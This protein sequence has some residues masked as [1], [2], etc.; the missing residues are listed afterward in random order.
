MNPEVYQII[1][2][3]L[4][5]ALFALGGTEIS[6]TIKGQKWIRRFLLPFLVVL[7]CFFNG[8]ALWRCLVYWIT[9]TA[10]LHL[11]YGDKLPYWRKLLTAIV[12]MLPSL[13]F[14]FTKWQIIFPILFVVMFFLSNWKYTSNVMKWKYV[15]ILTGVFLGITIADLL[16]LAY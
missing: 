13:F 9:Q 6:K 5:S 7:A 16:K 2:I 11:G 10:A 14:G 3:I 1:I 12:Y 8:I 15:E 4:S